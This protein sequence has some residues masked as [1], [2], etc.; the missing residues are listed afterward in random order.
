[1]A[2]RFFSFFALSLS[3][4]LFFVFSLAINAQESVNLVPN[5]SFEEFENG[6]PIN[7]NELPIGWSKWRNTPNSFS[8]CVEP[9]DLSDSLGWAPWTG[10][11]TRWPAHGESF[12]GFAA[13]SPAPSI[14]TQNNFREYI[15]CQLEEPMEIG[16]TYY[17][18]FKV[19][20]GYYGN[21]YNV[22]W[23]SNRL[24]AIFTTQSYLHQVNPMA[25]PNFAHLYSEEI[26][27][28][29]NWVSIE[30]GFVA[31]ST[32][33]HM[34]LGVFFDFDSLQTLLILPPNPPPTNGLGSYYFVDDICVS[35]FPDCKDVSVI[36]DSMSDDN[37]L[38]YPNPANETLTIRDWE[39]IHV[40]RIFNLNG[41]EILKLM[42]LKQSVTINTTAFKSGI[43]SVIIESKNKTKREKLVVVH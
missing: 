2:S 40:V 1:M 4:G 34:A 18:S 14:A 31:D 37:S 30:G 5:P 25:I 38:I 3:K 36:V 17:I 19:S 10:W 23:A 41:H 7:F 32:Y 21:H 6:C 43:Y 13:F 27:T 16:T 28:D 35:K 33:T 15:G 29:T 26:I 22:W 8:T 11:G 12:C 24:G 20:M 9:L 39:V 42:P